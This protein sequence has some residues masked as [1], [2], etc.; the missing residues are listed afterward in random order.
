MH[1]LV[2]ADS[3]VERFADLAEKPFIPGAKGSF[4][5]RQTASALHVLGLDEKVQLIDIDTAG[6]QTALKGSQVI[7][8]AVA[9]PFPLSQVSELA[10]AVPIRM[11]SL[12]SDELAKVLAADDSTVAQIIPKGTYPGVT[13]EV[14]SVALPAGAYTTTHMSN[15]TAYAI[16]KAFWSQRDGLARRNPSWDAVRPDTLAALGVKLHKGALRYY[17]EAGVTVPAALR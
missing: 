5:E 3:G 11:L 7:G 1:W 9:G 16:T 15:A 4:G 13:Q 8:I 17:K 14:T 6:A 10:R 12:S 2:R